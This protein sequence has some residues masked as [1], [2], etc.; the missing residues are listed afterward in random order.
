[1]DT[2]PQT[3]LKK[4]FEIIRDLKLE[5]S[6]TVCCWFT[7]YNPAHDELNAYNRHVQQKSKTGAVLIVDV[8]WWSGAHL[9]ICVEIIVT[10][11]RASSS[12]V[13]A[14]FSSSRSR[15]NDYDCS[16]GSTDKL[17]EPA[18]ASLPARAARPRTPTRQ[19]LRGR[20]LRVQKSLRRPD[21][22]RRTDRARARWLRRS[23]IICIIQSR[24]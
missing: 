13:S 15:T 12:D 6:T 9:H 4:H 11:Q 14:G 2:T 16:G 23:S 22:G 21:G 7:T 20:E 3:S 18:A 19:Y 5:L 17:T 10:S 1:M 8:N 24:A